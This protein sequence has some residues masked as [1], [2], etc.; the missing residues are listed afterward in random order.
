MIQ[1][2]VVRTFLS[3]MK[4]E[5]GLHKDIKGCITEPNEQFVFPYF[6][7]AEVKA[8]P[9]LAILRIWD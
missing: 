1:F 2:R 8:D 7:K 4:H 5:K 3:A 6:Q 9:Q